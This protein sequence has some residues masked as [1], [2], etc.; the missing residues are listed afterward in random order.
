MHIAPLHDRDKGRHL[1]RI[2]HMIAD[3]LLRSAL[4]LRIHYGK[5]RIV[6]RSLPA[7]REHL[8]HIVRH[9]MKLLR[10]HHQVHMA[11]IPHQ[12]R[13]SA[14]RHAPQETEHHPR[15]LLPQ[16]AHHSHF[17]NRLLLRH[18]PHG[19]G[20]QQHHVR[21]PLAFRHLVAPRHEHERHLL[22]VALVH[23]AAVCFDE[24]PGHEVRNW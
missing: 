12:L 4:L 7:P 19:A 15:A 1:P 18:V 5:S 8:I 9:A 6:H 13:P 21:V 17:A 22:G 16:P 10:P 2:Q 20:I 3:G 23:L 11:D 24:D 14:L